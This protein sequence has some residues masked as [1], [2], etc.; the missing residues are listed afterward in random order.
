MARLE[1]SAPS[2]GDQW[3]RSTEAAEALGFSVRTLKRY[4]HPESGFLL[5]GLHWLVGPFSN[6]P[7]RWNVPACRAVLHHRGIKARAELRIE[8]RLPVQAGRI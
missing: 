2:F 1:L 4:G 6:S 3:L 8:Q 5:P 7:T